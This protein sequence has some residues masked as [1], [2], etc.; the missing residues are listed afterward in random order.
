MNESLIENELGIKELPFD[1]S[2]FHYTVSA[3]RF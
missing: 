3:G 2:V 1:A